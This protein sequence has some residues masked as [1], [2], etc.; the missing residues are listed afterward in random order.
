M[1]QLFARSTGQLIVFVV[2]YIRIF[3][4][5]RCHHLDTQNLNLRYLSL[6]LNASFLNMWTC[7]QVCII[8]AIKVCR[9]YINYKYVAKVSSNLLRFWEVG[10]L[11]WTAASLYQ[12]RNS[13][14]CSP[15]SWDCPGNAAKIQRNFHKTQIE[16]LFSRLNPINS[17]EI[18]G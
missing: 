17:I 5:Q 12:A 3:N 15:N 13:G 4:S 16:Q 11:S 2:C 8:G 9:S 18:A 14:P 6:V 7:H 10:I 1:S